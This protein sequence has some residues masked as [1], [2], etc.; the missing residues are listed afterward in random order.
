[1]SAAI[2]VGVAAATAPAFAQNPSTSAGQSYPN[3]YVRIITGNAGNMHDIIVRQLG[4]R[5]SE[6]WGQSIVVENRGGAGLT[7]GTGMVAKA[8]P[9]GYTLLMSDRT[10]IAVAPSAFKGLSYD[11][12]K[13]LTPITLV[14]RA[15][16]VIVAHPSIPATKLREFI[17][18]AKQR[19][20][21][22]NY[23]GSGPATVTHI[24]RS[25]QADGRHRH[26][27]RSVQGDSGGDVGGRQR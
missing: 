9:D 5:L 3:R 15:P 10:A 2:V 13:D 18:Y 1:M 12:V 14:A 21:T 25:P 20:G 23:A 11:P 16:L 7:I 17:D 27:A 26:D 4:Q 8:T 24:G 6:R 22:L 19:P